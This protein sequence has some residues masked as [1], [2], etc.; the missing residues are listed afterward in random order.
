[1]TLKSKKM[2][3]KAKPM[4]Q[5][6]WAELEHLRSANVERDTFTSD[7]FTRY[8]SDATIVDVIRRI[9]ASMING[10]SGR[11]F[12]ITGSYGSGKSTLAIFLD[13]LLAGDGDPSYK[14]AIK[15]LDS[16][17]SDVSKMLADG[18]TN[19]DLEKDGFIRCT[20][21]SQS[22]PVAASVIRALDRG[23]RKRFGNKY[24]NT[25]FST[26]SDLRGAMNTVENATIRGNV[27]EILDARSILNIV[28]G[29]CEKAPVLILL[30]EF[31]K[32][33]EY[34]TKNNS[35]ADM[36]LL[37]MLAESGSGKKALPLF[38]ITMQHMAFE[39][40][41]EGVSAS[42]RREWSK[43]QGRF[44]DIPF[45]N[46]PQQTWELVSNSLS[47]KTPLTVGLNHWSKIEHKKLLE[48]TRKSIP[49]S[50]QINKCYPLHPLSLAVLPDLC[51]RYGQHERTLLSFIAGNGKHTVREFIEE[52]HWNP[53]NPST[54]GL[55]TLYDYFISG[56]RSIH[57]H[58]SANI[59]LLMEIHL[60]IRDSHGLSKMATKVLKT[61]GLLNL[62]SISGP[63]SA[64]SKMLK[65]VIENDSDR[66]SAINELTQRS[67]I[68][69]RDYADEYRVWRGTDVDLQASIDIIRRRYAKAPLHEILDQVLKLDSIVAARHGI[70]TGTMRTFERGFLDHKGNRIQESENDDGLILYSSDHMINSAKNIIKPVIIVEP[71]EDLSSLRHSA[72]AALSIKEILDTDPNVSRD[73]VARKELWERME[74]ATSS[75]EE[76]F[77]RVYD[78][79]ATWWYINPPKGKKIK[80]TGNRNGNIASI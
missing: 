43:V 62:L 26:A 5:M 38:L 78:K 58:T 2:S 79:N 60:V 35:T 71:K 9:S 28:T 49:N 65:Y 39:E 72:I 22:E 19:L 4:L 15:L 53:K 34:F 3:V 21:I 40:Y 11:A 66:N 44:D 20:I 23:A 56:H 54:I 69:H 52:N 76:E 63:L 18:Y 10:K 74:W 14:Q 70:R 68:T 30:D 59:T 27:A 51:T 6:V 29:M 7:M 32:N 77:R 80:L 37:Q 64:S 13:G 61:I 50:T 36:H 48:I 41:A 12:S 25:H 16:I 45:S 47:R 42:N 24:K 75:V 57:N 67:I 31:G 1:M 55:D 17:S 73:W 8:V 46:S 33:M